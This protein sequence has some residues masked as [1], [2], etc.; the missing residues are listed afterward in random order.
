MKILLL[1]S[2]TLIGLIGCGSSSNTT[3]VENQLKVFAS[4]LADN[5][6]KVIEDAEVLK[7]DIN[8]LFNQDAN[9]VAVEPDD[10][11]VNV[12]SRAEGI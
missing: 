5:E 7:G 6:A 10:N 8:L 2:F 9:P 3:V 4:Q 1:M 12:I 11:L